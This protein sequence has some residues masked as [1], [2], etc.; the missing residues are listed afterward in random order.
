MKGEA[1]AL[2]IFDIVRQFKFIAKALLAILE[3]GHSL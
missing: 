2:V 1:N 3:S